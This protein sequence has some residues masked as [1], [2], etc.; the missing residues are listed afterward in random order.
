MNQPELFDSGFS[1][2]PGR[3]NFGAKGGKKA[4]ILFRCSA[5]KCKF[6]KAHDVDLTERR[7]AWGTATTPDAGQITTARNAT[8]CK[9]HPNAFLTMTRVEGT[10]SAAHL[11]DARC[12]AAIGPICVCSCGGANHG[13][14]WL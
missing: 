6:C 7:E 12:L 10:L 14:G 11:C 3:R 4:R 1:I 2:G 8:Q 5:P 9:A 13:A